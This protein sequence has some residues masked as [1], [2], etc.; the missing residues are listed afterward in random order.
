MTDPA[1]P[2]A[3]QPP[4]RGRFLLVLEALP[5]DRPVAVRLRNLLKTALRRDELRCVRVTELPAVGGEDH[6]R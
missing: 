1:G 3:P 2:E 5:S 4:P 6:E